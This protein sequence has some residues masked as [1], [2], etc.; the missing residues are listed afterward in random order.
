VIVAANIPAAPSWEEACVA[1]ARRGDEKAFGEL[2]AAFAQRLYAQ[3][4]LP[5]LGN[6]HAAEDALAETFRAALEK[7]DSWQPRGQ[8]WFAWLCRIAINKATDLH[9]ER[10]RTGRALASFEELIGPLRV[11]DDASFAL[12][13]KR[14]ATLSREVLQGLSERYRRAVELRILEEKERADCADALGVT[15]GNFDVLLLRSLRAFRAAWLE[16]FGNEEKP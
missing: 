12:D 3:V 11:P 10:A 9:R 1:R 2:Y 6:P 13:Q 5:R 16:R 8:T 14:F 4:L 7:L 15:V